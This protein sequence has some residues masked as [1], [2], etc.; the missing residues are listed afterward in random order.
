MPLKLIPPTPGRNRFYRVRGTLM[1]VHVDMSS[2]SADKH[3][4][5]KLKKELE[6]RILM[7][8]KEPTK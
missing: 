2:G 5:E 1:G 6:T 3:D 7:G 8:S 4:G